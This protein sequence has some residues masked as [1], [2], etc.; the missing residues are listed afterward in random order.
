MKEFKIK[1]K[2]EMEFRFK[3]ISPVKLMSLQLCIDFDDFDKTSKLF[4]FILE[5]TQSNIA[6]TW[7]DVKMKDRE[8]YLPQ[9]IDKEVNAL[10]E[11][12]TTFLNEVIK[13]VFTRS[14]G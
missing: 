13:P 1:E 12:C 8:V 2:P 4:S 7:T 10:M 3:D 9:G 6:G 14:R 5:N 11:I